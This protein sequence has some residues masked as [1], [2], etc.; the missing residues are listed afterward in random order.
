MERAIGGGGDKRAGWIQAEEVADTVL[1]WTTT[2]LQRVE[3]PNRKIP[4]GAAVLSSDGVSGNV[5][6]CA[7]GC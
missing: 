5:R 1:L 6:R 3:T 4:R 2:S 7:S